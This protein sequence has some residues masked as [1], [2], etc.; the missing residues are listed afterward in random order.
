MKDQN[1]AYCVEGELL[2][3]LEL[4]FVNGKLKSLLI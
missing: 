2:D 1:C 4:R 3:A